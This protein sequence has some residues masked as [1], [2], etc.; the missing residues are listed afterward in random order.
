MNM[1]R[2]WIALLCIMTML[3]SMVCGCGQ[4]GKEEE[5][6][7]TSVS[8]TKTE[9]TVKNETVTEETTEVTEELE[10]VE[11]DWYAMIYKSQDVD[12]IQAALD[13]YFLE[14]LNCKVNLHFMLPADYNTQVPT[15]LSSGEKVDMVYVNTNIPYGTYAEMG[16]F[17]PIDT[18]WDEYGPNVKNLFSEGV[19][20]GVRHTD[21]HI[22]AV[23]TLKDNAY[24]IGYTY[25]DTLATELGIDMA[26]TGWESFNDIEELLTEALALRNEKHP[27]WKDMPLIPGTEIKIP[28]FFAGEQFVSGKMFAICNIPGIEVA[29][30]YDVDTVFNLYETDA[31]REAVLLKQRLVASGISAYD[32]SVFERN[33]MYE[34][35]TLL[36]PA[37]GYTWVEESIYGEEF[38]TKLAVFDNV[39]TDTGNYT[40]A[41][42]A[43]GANC[44]DPE[45]A[46]MVIDAFNSDPYLATM[47]RFGVEGEHWELDAEGNMQLCNRNADATNP[48]WLEWYGIPF[49]NLT[50]IDGP[51]S[52]IGEDGIM[53]KK[54]AEYNDNAILA[55]HMGFVFDT[56]PVENEIAACN[57]VIG[58]YY[59]IQQG[60]L[61][62]QD[63]VNAAV[64]E[65]V[66][67]LKANGSDKIVAEVQAQLDA[68]L[69]NK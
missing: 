27:E 49:G 55:A 35:S 67:K 63:A 64:D 47:M 48:G 8:E 6:E 26:N 4:T 56:A 18:I 3:I 54:M 19:W 53:L 42:T 20:E 28:Y 5:K 65:F 40:T 11:L 44:V 60:R 69:A 13:E 61:D 57:N 21:G 51:E 25:N 62:S 14:K 39:W 15:M 58:E 68:W 43:I 10:Y 7:S 29:P 30:E 24:I 16:A 12:I 23:P 36:A 38:D 22:Y 52:R 2:R 33:V 32:Y 1:K 59:Y 41:C 66:A 46:L 45:R 17:Y 31:Y 9:E 34:P 50:I 37:W